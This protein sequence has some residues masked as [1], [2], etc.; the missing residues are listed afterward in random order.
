MDDGDRAAIVRF[1]VEALRL[2]GEL[3]P[4]AA[5]VLA[6]TNDWWWA[7]DPIQHL[8]RETR[9]YAGRIAWADR[10]HRRRTVPLGEMEIP[11]DPNDEWGARRRIELVHDVTVAFSCVGLRAETGLALAVVGDHDRAGAARALGASSREVDTGRKRIH[12]KQDDLARL[13]KK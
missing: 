3:W 8:R 6:L 9:A 13:L 10:D 5:E 4:V 11:V 2:P 1:T 7:A 12:R